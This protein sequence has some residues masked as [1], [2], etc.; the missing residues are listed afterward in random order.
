MSWMYVI[1]QQKLFSGVLWLSLLHK[2]H[3]AFH[4]VLG[5]NDLGVAVLLDVEGCVD[6]HLQNKRF[7]QHQV[8]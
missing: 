2:R 3:K 8:R 6:V 1:V 5:G 7:H 4:P